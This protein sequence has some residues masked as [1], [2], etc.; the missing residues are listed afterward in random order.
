MIESDKINQILL[1]LINSLMDEGNSLLDVD[2]LPSN[3]M[4]FMHDELMSRFKLTIKIRNV[5][6]VIYD[7]EGK[8]AQINFM[9]TK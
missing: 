7:S 9:V 4:K 3:R 5:T 6:V 8:Y 1:L 2:W